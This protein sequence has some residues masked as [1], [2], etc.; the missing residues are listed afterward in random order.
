MRAPSG[1]LTAK[2]T[3]GRRISSPGVDCAGVLSSPVGEAAPAVIPSPDAA[4]SSPASPDEGLVASSPGFAALG[5]A[6]AAE[7]DAAASAGAAGAGVGALA[8]VE[9]AP[10]GSECS[11]TR[12]WKVR[13]PW[14]ARTHSSTM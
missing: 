9:L 3:P 7:D 10:T 5:L 13:S 4:P 12:N 2:V 14:P 1:V 6:P 8:A 11:N